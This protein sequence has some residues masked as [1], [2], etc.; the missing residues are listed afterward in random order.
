MRKTLFVLLG[1]AGMC[2]VAAAQ[3]PQKATEKDLIGTWAGRYSGASTGAFEMTITRDAEGRLGGT[4]SPK[5]DDGEAYTAPFTSV[6]FA[7]G[8]ATMTFTDPA[9][10]VDIT[11]EATPEG[12]SIKGTYVV[13]ARADGSEAERGTFTATKKP[14]KSWA[15]ASAR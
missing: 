14:A 13:H 12:S 3:A 6:K 8:K 11:I 15:E 7:D 5:A 4:V 9:G 2:A 10:N 1:L